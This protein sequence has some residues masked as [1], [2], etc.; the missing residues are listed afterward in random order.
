MRSDTGRYIAA[1]NLPNPNNMLGVKL[2]LLRG[3]DE[4]TD[5]LREG[6]R[7]RLDG[8]LLIELLDSIG[9]D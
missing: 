9:V 2:R 4:I 3:F 7:L 8:E 5:M 6:R 1:A